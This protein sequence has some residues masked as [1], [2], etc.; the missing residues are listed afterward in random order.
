MKTILLYGFLGQQFG[1]VHEYDVRTPAEAVRALSVT[2]PGFQRAVVEGGAYRVSIG[3]REDLP[4]ADLRNPVSSKETIRIIPVVHGAGRGLGQI[5]L[6]A[7]LIAFSV[8]NPGYGAFSIMGF[9]SSIAS[10]AGSI[11]FNLL[12]GGLSQMMFSSEQA[13]PSAAER[14]ENKPSFSFDGA[15]NTAGQ[16]NPIPVCYGTVEIGSQVISAGLSVEQI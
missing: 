10:I 2:V 3:G 4:L 6:G 11:G 5:I 9:S 8:L 14:P 1:K 13:Q 7:G 12:L 16:G 15:V